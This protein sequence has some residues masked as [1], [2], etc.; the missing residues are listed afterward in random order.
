MN[1]SRRITELLK[2][3]ASHPNHLMASRLQKMNLSVINK[4]CTK[5]LLE[6]ARLQTDLNVRQMLSRVTREISPT[7]SII[8]SELSG[9]S[10]DQVLKLVGE[11]AAMLLPV[12]L[13][14]QEEEAETTNHDKN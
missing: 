7:G 1:N 8:V 4:R 9:I 2:I 13:R 3:L 6:L 10:R 14:R 5:A 11:Y 12:F